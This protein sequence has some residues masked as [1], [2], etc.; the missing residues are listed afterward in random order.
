MGEFIDKKFRDKRSGKTRRLVL[1]RDGSICQV[2]GTVGTQVHH[3]Q[4]LCYGGEDSPANAVVICDDCHNLA[5]DDWRLFLLFQREAI[6]LKKV[7]TSA[8]LSLAKAYPDARCPSV[9]ELLDETRERSW[10]L[11]KGYHGLWG[12]FESNEIEPEEAIVS[13]LH[14]KDAQMVALEWIET[15]AGQEDSRAILARDIIR[16]IDDY[17]SE[18]MNICAAG[19]SSKEMEA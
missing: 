13:F 1:K 6:T 14:M 16:I 4:P 7:I 17:V 11:I 10:G 18:L 5:P 12:D 2:C 8:Y 3:I 19:P 9:D 15:I